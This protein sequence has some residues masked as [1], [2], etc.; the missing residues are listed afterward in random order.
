MHKRFRWSRSGLYNSGVLRVCSTGP[1][2]ARRQMRFDRR[3]CSSSTYRKYDS[4]SRLAGLAP[5]CRARSGPIE[6]PL[7]HFG[8]IP[9]HA[10]QD[11]RQHTTAPGYVRL[12]GV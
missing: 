5:P 10:R 3:R 4:S 2:V 6:Q 1:P 12:V 7:T 11:Q 9:M 8:A